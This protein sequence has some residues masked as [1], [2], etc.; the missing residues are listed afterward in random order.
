MHLV[1]AIMP[2]RGRSIWAALAVSS[3]MQQSYPN[4]QLLILDDADQPSFPEGTLLPGVAYLR[5]DERL[6]IPQKRNILCRVAAG[7]IIAHWDSDD[8]SDTG[9]LEDQI[10]RLEESQCSVTGYSS[11]LF[12]DQQSRWGRYVG[13]PSFYALG[14]SLCYRKSWWRDHQFDE[15][16]PINED[17]D[18]VSRARH[19]GQ[20]ISVDGA[21]VMVARVHPGNTSPKNVDDYK[22]V[23]AATIPSGF[24]R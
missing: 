2:T 3:F 22:A 13:D 21:G 24:L 23:D 16:R 19:A 12:C 6:N 20:F 10:R 9:R 8:W 15:A 1:T 17:F 4:K 14:S 7:Q 5:I 18:F 11:I